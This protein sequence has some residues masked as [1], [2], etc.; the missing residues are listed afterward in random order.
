M[1]W[2]ASRDLYASKAASDITSE[3]Y[4]VGDADDLTLQ[5]RG[6]PSTTTVQVT[7]VNG[8]TSAIDEDDWTSLVT[9]SGETVAALDTGFG[10][11]RL[12]RS[13]TTAARLRVWNRSF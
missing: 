5:L 2:S 9:V 11:L 12:Q 7:N 4:W 8:R 6:S 13:E 3:S 10:W 1:P